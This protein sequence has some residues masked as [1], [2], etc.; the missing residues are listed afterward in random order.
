MVWPIICGNA[1]AC[2]RVCQCTGL[3]QLRVLCF[4]LLKDGD[5]GIGV[6][7]DGEEILVCT[8]RF[9]GVALNSIGTGEAEMRERG[10]R[11][12]GNYRV[13][14]DELVEIR[15]QLPCP[16]TVPDTPVLE[17]KAD[18]LGPPLYWGILRSEG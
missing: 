10:E 7:P 11:R 15:P 4:G 3:L 17:H 2:D 12:I 18:K 16:G 9:G 13:M 1:M 14:V 6:F 5:V 8:L